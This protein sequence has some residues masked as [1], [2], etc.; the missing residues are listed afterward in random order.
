MFSSLKCDELDAFVIARQDRDKPKF[1]AKSK[2]PKKG[3]TCE[4]KQGERNKIRIA[5]NCRMMKNVLVDTMPFD[6]NTVNGDVV[7]SGV[8]QLGIVNVYKNWVTLAISLLDLENMN[9]MSTI[10]D[11]QE[12]KADHLLKILQ[13][14]FQ[15][16]LM[17]RIDNKI[18]RTQWSMIFAHTNLAVSAACMILSNHIKDKL[19]CVTDADCLL[20]PNTHNFYQC[21][22]FSS[23]EGAYLY[24]NSNKG[25]F[26]R[27]GKVS[28]R[29]FTRQGKE[30]FKES[31]K[32]MYFLHFYY[33]YPLSCCP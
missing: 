1:S 7:G 29:G 24:F 19:R 23:R 25:C 4:A 31:K 11:K 16:H 14:R 32:V 9:V 10:T 22:Q 2:I 26:I 28:G 21:V 20:Q 15:Q 3:T 12:D 30:H 33:L 8:D 6:I 27:S 17:A 13:D 18:K 5:F